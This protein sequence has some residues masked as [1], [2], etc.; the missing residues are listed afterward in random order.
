M[1]KKV[2]CIGIIVACIGIVANAA[3]PNLVGWWKMD[4]TSGSIAHDSSGTDNHGTLINGGVWTTGQID[5]GLRLDGV[6][7][8]VSLPIGP[9]ISTLKEASFTIWVNW[10]GTGGGWQRILDFGTGTAN[11][12]YLCPSTG[13][14]SSLRVA[15]T[16]NNGVWDEFDSNKGALPTG[17]HH[18]AVTV[19]SSTKQMIMYLDGEVVGSISNITNTVDRLGNTTQN[20]LGRSQ[21]ADPYFNGVLDDFRIYN[22][23]LTQDQVRQVMFPVADNASRPFPP[24]QSSDVRRDVVLSWRPGAYKGTHDVYFGTSRQEVDAAS[25]LDPRGVLVSK[26]QDPNTFAPGLL[27]YNQQYYWRIDEVNANDGYIH[28]GD[29]WTFTVEPYSY[30]VQPI[31]ATAS[32]SW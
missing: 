10:A 25:R 21:Y 27:A 29:V 19:S 3:D 32:S 17:W 26:G 4:E 30:P 31:D 24:D 2:V 20:W 12:I 13:T 6:D 23:I 7:D 18:I 22:R 28:K 15:I 9:L 16:A 14:T 5:G 1:N 11:Y 8:H